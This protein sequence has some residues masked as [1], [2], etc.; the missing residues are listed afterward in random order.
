[1]M[2]RERRPLPRSF[3]ESED[4]V[5]L[6]RQLIGK[7]L[8]TCKNGCYTSGIITET[9]AY[10]GRNGLACHANDGLRTDRTEIMYGP[11][12]FAYVYLCYGI[13]HLFNVVVNK[14]ELADAILIRAIEPLEGIDIMKQRRKIKKSSKPIA[15]G[16]GMMSQ[17][18]GIHRN[19]YG[20]DLTNGSSPIWIEDCNLPVIESLINASP[21]I[22]VDYAGE[23]AMRN[24]RFYTKQFHSF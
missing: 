14:K 16:P 20:V 23:D 13:H 17:A 3:Y 4:V 22:G 21:R 18:L 6:S 8:C 9:E 10:S 2:H 19:D 24:W 11:G 15:A 7:V 5:T 1:M 12:G